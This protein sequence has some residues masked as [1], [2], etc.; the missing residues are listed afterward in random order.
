MDAGINRQKLL[1]IGD[2]TMKEYKELKERHPAVL[3]HG[4]ARLNN[5]VIDDATG[6]FYMTK[7]TK[8]ISVHLS[9]NIKVGRDPRSER[10][11]KEKQRSKRN[12]FHH[13]M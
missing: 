13:L 9:R 11:L 10:T 5:F 6:E 2:E 7:I 1:E 3:C 12:I 8:K 4:D